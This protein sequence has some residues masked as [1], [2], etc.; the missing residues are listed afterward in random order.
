MA[1]RIHVQVVKQG[2]EAIKEWRV[3]NPGIRLDLIAADLANAILTKSD[4]ERA[5]LTGANL[6]G[7]NLVGCDLTRADLRNADLSGAD[8]RDANLDEAILQGVKVDRSTILP[9]L[10]CCKSISKGVRDLY[11]MMLDYLVMRS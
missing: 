5:A 10:L 9:H 2:A 4:L 6:K 7:A 3:G 1:D 8:L 11:V